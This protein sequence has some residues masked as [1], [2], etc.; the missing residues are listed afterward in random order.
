[1]PGT[2]RDHVHETPW[3]TPNR[4][5]GAV[6]GGTLGAWLKEMAQTCLELE[7]GEP[8]QSPITVTMT[9]R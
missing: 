3:V 6:L 4:T 7:D 5:P 9:V 2:R 8:I 1:V